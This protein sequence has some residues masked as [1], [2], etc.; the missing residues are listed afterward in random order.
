MQGALSPHSRDGLGVVGTAARG[1]G[2]RLE[3]HQPSFG[4]T[5]GKSPTPGGVVQLNSK[6]CV[7]PRPFS[8]PVAASW[9]WQGVLWGDQV[10]G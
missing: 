4:V 6:L 10:W 2:A 1:T 5:E 3:S 8:A 9:L 7:H